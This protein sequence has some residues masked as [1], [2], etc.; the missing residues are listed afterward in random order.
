M[1][2]TVKGL[3]DSFP[4]LFK[5]GRHLFY[6]F[7]KGMVNA[8]GIIAA[9]AIVVPIILSMLRGI[10]WVP[11][12]GDFVTKVAERVEIQAQRR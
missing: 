3:P 12:V 7:L 11:L 2:A 1:R 5:P 10:Q 6:T 4:F 9:F 8:M